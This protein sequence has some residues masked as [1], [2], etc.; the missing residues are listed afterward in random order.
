MQLGEA[1]LGT[2]ASEWTGWISLQSQG[3][4]KSLLQHH[5]SKAPPPPP[6]AQLSGERGS[7]FSPH[8]GRAWLLRQRGM[9]D[10]LRKTLSR[11][12]GRRGPHATGRLG[13]R[14][15]A[16]ATVAASSAA[17]GDAGG[18]R[19]APSG[20]RA[21]GA[22]PNLE[23]PQPSPQAWGP[24]AGVPG[25]RPERSG[26]LGPAL[27]GWKEATPPGGGLTRASLYSRSLLLPGRER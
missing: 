7:E 2:G 6:R 24:E 1:V 10:P 9:T 3:T 20:E 19:D 25:G 23:R 18:T 26:A 5:N 22:R 4:L 13:L 8:R 27:R 11:L 21:S 15:A 14:A 17:E 12:R 16:A